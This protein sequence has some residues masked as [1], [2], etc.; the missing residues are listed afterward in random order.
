MV[1]RVLAILLGVAGLLPQSAQS[2]KTASFLPSVSISL[3]PNML[4]ETVQISY[5]LIGP[6]GGHGG[7]AAQRTGGH[8]YEIPTMVDG[9]AAAEIRMIVYAPG[10]EIQTF[11]IPLAGDSRVSQEFPCQR[12]VLNA[13]LLWH[14]RWVCYWVSPRNCPSRRE[15][16]VSSRLALFQRRR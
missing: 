14:C 15:R 8:S 7:Y 12:V 4:S 13:W 2:P 9:K 3:P 16:D 6:F 10:C 5:F 1:G 11:V